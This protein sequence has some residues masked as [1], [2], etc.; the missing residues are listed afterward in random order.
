MKY[1]L[2]THTDQE[3]CAFPLWHYCDVR[4]PV[5]SMTS[6][7]Y[8]KTKVEPNSLTRIYNIMDGLWFIAT[9]NTLRFTVLCP[10]KQNEAVMVNPPLGIMK[11]NMPCST[12]SSY[13]TL[14]PYYH[15]ESK[16]NIQ[17]QFIDNPKSYNG[18]SL[19]IWKSFISA[20]PNFTKTDIPVI[21]KD[22]KEIPMRHLILTA[23]KFR[24]SG[25][26]SGPRCI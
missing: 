25:Q 24:K 22:I 15:N 3:H 23:Y 14:L 5:Y 13:L 8:C 2:L 6:S 19:Q 18:S 9:Q 4:S 12:K 11:L 1:I 21:L 26:L 20:V 16:S 7:K 17:D 10:Q